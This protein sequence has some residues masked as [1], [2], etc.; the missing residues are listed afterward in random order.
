ML[1]RS[2]EWL[3]KGSVYADQTGKDNDQLFQTMRKRAD[4]RYSSSHRCIPLFSA[5]KGRLVERLKNSLST[6]CG[7]RS[8]VKRTSIHSSNRSNQSPR[9]PTSSINKV[10]FR[11]FTSQSLENEKTRILIS[12]VVSTNRLRKVALPH[13][14]T[15]LGTS[16]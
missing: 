1:F 9:I 6:L 14:L 13:L 8:F 10:F 3:K 16:A 12:F 11:Y 4:R 2:R 5:T 15:E 7:T